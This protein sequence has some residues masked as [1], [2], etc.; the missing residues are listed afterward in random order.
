MLKFTDASDKITALAAG[1]A[2]ALDK[3]ARYTP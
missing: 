1:V 3:I 2:A